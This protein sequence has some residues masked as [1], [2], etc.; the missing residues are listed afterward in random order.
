MIGTIKVNKNTLSHE[1]I[2]SFEYHIVEIRYT[3][4]NW[5]I[6]TNGVPGKNVL[7]KIKKPSFN[8][9][10]ISNIESEYVACFTYKYPT[11]YLILNDGSS[12]S[13]DSSTESNKA[14]KFSVDDVLYNLKDV[15]EELKLSFNAGLSGDYFTKEE[16]ALA[17]AEAATIF[18]TENGLN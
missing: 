12:D 14:D 9:K 8:S 13:G 6:R 2:E 4:P 7:V 11:W 5:Y 18:K 16:F 15:Y 1:Y 3:Y 17:V 10:D